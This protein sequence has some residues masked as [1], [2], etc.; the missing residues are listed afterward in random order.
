MSETLQQRRDNIA[1]IIGAAL[2]A[3]AYKHTSYPKWEA[4]IQNTVAFTDQLIK[5]LDASSGDV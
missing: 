5:A 3:E 1:A 4:V 2:L